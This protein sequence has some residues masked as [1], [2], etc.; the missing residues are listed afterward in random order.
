MFSGLVDLDEYTIVDLQKPKELQD[1]PG[2]GSN[3]VDTAH[4]EGLGE[5][6]RIASHEVIRTL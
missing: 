3:L 4:R 6:L 5:L 2:F 1:F